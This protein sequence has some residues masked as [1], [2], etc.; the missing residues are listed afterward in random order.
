MALEILHRKA[1]APIRTTPLL[2][3]HGA[4]HG[5]WCWDEHLLLY[6]A[7]KG[8]EAY[9][10]SL[11]GHGGSSGR[12]AWASVKN[13]VT[14]VAQ[15][16]DQITATHG[17]R[18]AVIGHSLG[19]F[20]VQKYLEK[21]AAPAGVLVASIPVRGFFPAFVRYIRR[22][23]LPALLTMLTLNPRHMLGTQELFH[24]TMLSPDFSR[25]QVRRYFGKTNRE[26]FRVA[27]DTMFLNLPKPKSVTAPMLVMAAANDYLFTHYEQQ[28]T[29]QAYNALLDILPDTAHDMM[30]EK[31]WQTLADRVA[32]WL[33]EQGI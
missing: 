22:H 2:F 8:Y 12:L 19:G 20:V 24:K 5:A 16:A 32:R 15:V 17:H 11:R 23:P 6:F 4:W 14:D 18:P 33:D 26:S 31:D 21:H 10:V 3:V 1:E 13:Y 9:A 30:L 28:R 27:L 7:R 29:A 25:E